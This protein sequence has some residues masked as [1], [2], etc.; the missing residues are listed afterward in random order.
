MS[1][2]TRLLLMMVSV[3]LLPVFSSGLLLYYYQQ[4][5]KNNILEFHHSL[6]RLAAS[7]MVRYMEDVTQ[8]LA[9]TQMV[10]MFYASGEKEKARDVLLDTLN[11][12]RDFLAAAVLDASGR[13]L[14]RVSSDEYP[15]YAPLDRS[16][17]A[18]FR[19]SRHSGNIVFGSFESRQGPPVAPMYCPLQGDRYLLLLV[20][21]SRFWESIQG[22]TIGLSGRVY[23]SD[24]NGNIFHF[25]GDSPPAVAPAALKALL[26]S[27]APRFEALAAPDGKYVG[28]FAPV[29]RS[30]LA[31]LTLQKRA[32]AFRHVRA[33]TYLLLVLLLAVAVAAYYLALYYARLIQEPVSELIDGADRVSAQQFDLPLDQ[34]LA[35]G[36]FAGLFTAF[37]SM[38]GEM[39]KY[40]DLQVDKMMEEK[41]KLDLLVSLLR[42][43]I[44]LADEGGRPLFV[45]G[46]AAEL[47]RA[48]GGGA[49]APEL[50]LVQRFT[51][52]GASELV[53]ARIFDEQKLRYYKPMSEQFRPKNSPPVFL[54]VLRDVTLEHEIDSMKEE[55]FNSVAHDLRAPLLGLQG[56]IRLLAAA[57]KGE[58]E[59]QH[60]AG[61]KASSKRLSALV[62]DILDT[63]KMESG[64]LQLEREEFEL[65]ELSAQVLDTIRPA[66]DEKKIDFSMDVNGARPLLLKADRRLLERVLANLL[67]NA[68]KFT[69]EGG[70]IV[71][72]AETAG[73]RVLIKVCDS[74]PGIPEKSRETVF[75]KFRQ[76]ES[77]AAAGK[78]Y[79][80]GLSIARKIAEL[81]GGSIRAG[82]APGGGA[83]FTVEL[84]L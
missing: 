40:R 79:G 27:L 12:N 63:A 6:S 39:K 78:G 52:A 47:L 19:S 69:P 33:T 7:S 29:P 57:C 51:G 37:N 38:Q 49:S 44:V 2:F 60:L 30:N 41:R 26:S 81:H 28:A 9:F 73:T 14:L 56:Y 34:S 83:E 4:R 45:N 10:E 48:L 50:N 64:T 24:S 71:L 65:G 55:F 1:F 3:G 80:L 42:D 17:D 84:P 18:G 59:Q 76:L 21:F 25:P 32:E 8:R 70:K 5:Y 43:G 22:Q 23:L 61:M 31:V 75:E 20:D 36:E 16:A 77:G 82:E 66:L 13:E 58:A 67:S 54:L 74:G 68:L 15:L 11:S 72:L 35:W 46:I 53:E 62:E